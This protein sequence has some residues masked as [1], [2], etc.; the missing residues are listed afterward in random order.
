MDPFLGFP[1]WLSQ[2]ASCWPDSLEACGSGG[3][4]HSSAKRSPYQFLSLH[5]RRLPLPKTEFNCSGPGPCSDPGEPC[6]H[7]QPNPLNR[8]CQGA[9]PAGIKRSRIPW[10]TVKGWTAQSGSG[11][12][13]PFP[14]GPCLLKCA[15]G[16]EGVRVPPD[17]PNPHQ[18]VSSSRRSTADF[19]KLN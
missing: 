8:K 16:E 14:P 3:R 11:S 9:K 10:R 12:F 17:D 13:F 6:C 15:K 19:L 1:P 5:L 4:E 2:E 7:T 18:K